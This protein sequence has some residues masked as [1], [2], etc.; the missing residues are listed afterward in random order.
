MY[1]EDKLGL[2]DFLKKRPKEEGKGDQGLDIPPPPPAMDKEL[3]KGQESPP[4]VNASPKAY[5]TKDLSTDLPN[6]KLNVPDIESKG[7]V[8]LGMPKPSMP[9]KKMEAPKKGIQD[10]PTFPSLKEDTGFT[11]APPKKDFEMPMPQ[12]KGEPVKEKKHKIKFKRS[13]FE[14]KDEKIYEEEK[15]IM[16]KG[17]IDRDYRKP[18]YIKLDRYREILR[19]INV[20]NADGRKSDEI[21]YISVKSKED[22]DKSFQKWHDIMVDCQNKFIFIEKTL[23]KGDDK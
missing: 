22:R 9:E 10:M 11:A 2:L 19:A 12:P 13:A 8:D 14:A 7:K 5:P 17:K 18:L 3:L 16:D 21:L 20:I 4:P 1:D 6:F 23:F 15:E